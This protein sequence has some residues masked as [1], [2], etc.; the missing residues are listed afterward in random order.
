MLLP[1]D[2]F[3]LYIGADTN[4]GKLVSVNFNS[5]ITKNSNGELVETAYS[6]HFPVKLHLRTLKQLTEAESKELIRKGLSIGRPRGYSFSPDAFV[7]LLSCHVDIFGLI[8]NKLAI[9]V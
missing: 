8:E 2:Y 9:S 3:H 4:I 5:C 7:Y 6:D 1:Q